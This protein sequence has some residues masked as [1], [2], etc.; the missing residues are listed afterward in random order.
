MVSDGDN[1]QMQASLT[2]ELEL[3]TG[4]H[5]CLSQLTMQAIQYIHFT[6]YLGKA[7][8]FTNFFVLFF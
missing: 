2:Q 1:I 3:L 5:H 7:S 8:A 4:L 6:Y